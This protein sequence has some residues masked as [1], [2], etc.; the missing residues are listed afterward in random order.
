MPGRDYLLLSE[1]AAIGT[2]FGERQF[3]T[4]LA[5]AIRRSQLEPDSVWSNGLAWCSD[6]KAARI[7]TRL[8]GAPSLMPLPTTADKAYLMVSAIRST[9]AAR[10]APGVKPRH[11][12]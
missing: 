12:G 10:L 3:R 1:C 9:I 6:F 5:T 11:M 4:A 2:K 8:Y 7:R